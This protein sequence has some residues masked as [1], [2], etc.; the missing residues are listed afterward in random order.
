MAALSRLFHWR[1]ALVAVKPETLIRWHR[2]GFRLFWRWKSKPSG[3]PPLPAN[4]R[5]LIRTMAADNIGW[6]EE[7]IANELSLKLGIR[8]SPRTVGKYMQRQRNSRTPDPGQR[9]LTFVRNHADAIVACDFCTVVTARFRILYVMVVIEVGQRSILH[10][11]VTAHPTAEWTLQQLREALPEGPYRYLIHDN[12]SIFSRELDRQIADLGIT[13]LRTPIR[14]PLANCYCERL[15][16]TLRRECLD[17]MIPLGE[18]HLRHIVKEFSEYYNGARVHMSL[19]PGV[20]ASRRTRPSPSDH[21]HSIRAGH[22]VKSSAVLG[23]L[24]HEY[25]LESV[26]A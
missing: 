3:R 20:P 9:W 2:K 12:D 22:R 24:H 5:E 23:G 10:T 8:V 11:N 16:G 4:I 21:R 13:I 18:R 7:R 14:A 19:G 25:F 6:G 1:E 17:F 15:V 26:A